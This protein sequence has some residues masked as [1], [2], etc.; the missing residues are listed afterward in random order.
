MRTTTFPSFF[1][2]IQLFCFIT[3]VVA[4]CLL[5][6]VMTYD[7]YVAICN[8]L[9]YPNL[10]HL[11][12]GKSPVPVFQETVLNAF[13]HV[14]Y[15]MTLP[16]FASRET[17]CV[18]VSGYVCEKERNRGREIK[19]KN[20]IKICLYLYFK[21]GKGLFCPSSVFPLLPTSTILACNGSTLCTVLGM[22]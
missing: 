14:L 12:V 9:Y 18:Y 3:L 1:C 11:V 17:Q 4:E 19:R 6:G 8:P 16:H 5:L 20:S 13:I 7:C 15:I 22:Q 2:D 21:I 10:M